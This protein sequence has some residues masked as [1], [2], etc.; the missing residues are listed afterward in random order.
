M[1]YTLR[2]ERDEAAITDCGGILVSLNPGWKGGMAILSSA[3]I[4]DS[5]LG[6]HPYFQALVG[7]YANHITKGRFTLEGKEYARAKQRLMPARRVEGF[8]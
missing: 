8:R 6:Q 1:H 7:R 5:Y 3:S 4:L 2:N